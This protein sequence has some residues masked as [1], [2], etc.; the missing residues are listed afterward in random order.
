MSYKLKFYCLGAPVRGQNYK[1]YLRYYYKGNTLNIPTDYTLTK[2]QVRLVNTGE[3]GGNLQTDLDNIR[4]RAIQVVEVL[5]LKNNAYPSPTALKVFLIDI[6]STLPMERYISKYL[7]SLNKAKPQTKGLYVD[8]FKHWTIYYEGNIKRTPVNE[9][10]HKE[11]VE[12]FGRWLIDRGKIIK[13]KKL[14]RTTIHNIKH[15]VFRLLN[16]IA[17]MQHLNKIDNYLV[18]PQ[19]SIKYTPTEEEMNTLVSVDTKG[20]ENLRKVQDLV[21]VNSF[22]GLRI[23]ELLNIKVDNIKS[24]S[25]HI[26][27]RFLEYKKQ[28]HRNVVLIDKKGMEIVQWYIHNASGDYLWKIGATTFNDL[29]KDLA[30]IAFGDKTTYLYNVE[31]GDEEKVLIKKVI[32]SHCIRRYAIHRNINMYG[33]DVARSFSGHTNYE[34][35]VK[36][37]SKGWLSEQ[38]ALNKLISHNNN[39]SE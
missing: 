2:D 39:N 15:S 13:E 18:Q 19:T 38:V 9:L 23:S 3:L 33:I 1:T 30:E 10:V 16:F 21:Y 29:L 34:T 25:T 11:T 20:K 24:Q 28:V 17:E 5:N 7:Q 12:A 27:L 36:H 26:T 37:Y 6:T 22:W 31:M 8:H 32:S 14:K 4:A 35:V